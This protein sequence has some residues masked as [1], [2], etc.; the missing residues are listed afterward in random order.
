MWNTRIEVQAVKKFGLAKQKQRMVDLRKHRC[1]DKPVKAKVHGYAQNEIRFYAQTVLKCAS[2]LHSLIPT[3][4][5][6]P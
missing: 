5:L 6:A 1:A 3:P 2:L 4:S